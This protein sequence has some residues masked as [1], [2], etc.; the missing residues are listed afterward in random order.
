MYIL[1]KCIVS[2]CRFELENTPHTLKLGILDS[3]CDDVGL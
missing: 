2:S 3:N 1:S